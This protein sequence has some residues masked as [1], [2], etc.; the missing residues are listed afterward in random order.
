VF[1]VRYGL[2]SNI[3]FRINSVFK[4]VRSSL[5][6]PA[7]VLGVPEAETNGFSKQKLLGILSVTF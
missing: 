7:S 6:D 2:N 3:L 4:G 1:P 5:L